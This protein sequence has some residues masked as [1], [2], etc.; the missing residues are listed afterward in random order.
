MNR[1]KEVAK[2]FCG[3]EAFH[4]LLHG[5]LWTSGTAF[6]ALGFTTTAT[7]DAIGTTLNGGIAVALGV[8]GWRSPK[9]AGSKRTR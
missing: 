4:A 8:Y 2:F 5:Y 3:F 6:T 1:W 7:W 9:P